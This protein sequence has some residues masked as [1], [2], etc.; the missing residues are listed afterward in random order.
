MHTFSSFKTQQHFVCYHQTIVCRR[1]TIVCSQQ[2]IVCSGQT[3]K[4]KTL[5]AKSSTSLA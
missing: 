3:I 5:R 4:Q 2:T 1:Q